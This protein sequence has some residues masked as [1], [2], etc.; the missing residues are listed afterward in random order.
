MKTAWTTLVVSL[1]VM[2]AS[3]QI[4]KG[5]WLLGASSA[6]GYNSYSFNNNS[7][8]LSVFNIN[9]K[10][11][12]FVA[13]NVAVGL[14]LGYLNLSQTNTTS[15]TTF[16]VFSRFFVS[17][18]VFLGAGFNSVSTSAG[19]GMLSVN[20]SSSVFPFEFGFAGFIS[21]R[22]AIEPSINYVVGDEKGGVN[23]NGLPI[24]AK[25]SIGFSLGITLYL[26]RRAS[27][28]Q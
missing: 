17:K 9:T 19:T 1:M 26:N 13:N 12:Y 7:A 6:L 25:S 8:N 2:T 27:D 15:V 10:A 4:S 3:A 16:G 20:A 5:T 18:S 24:G 14:N 22:I 21:D 23:F 28:E 11:G